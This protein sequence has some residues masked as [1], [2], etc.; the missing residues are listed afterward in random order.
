MAVGTLEI[1]QDIPECESIRVIQKLKQSSRITMGHNVIDSTHTDTK[2]AELELT[3]RRELAA[4]YRLLDYYHMTELT[5][6]HA[7]MRLPGPE[8]NFLLN[9]YGLLFEEI[10]ASNLVQV[11]LAG[12]IM[13]DRG[14]VISP[15]AFVIHSAIHEG[16]EDAKSILHLHTVDGSAVAA[17]RDGLLPVNQISMAFYNRLGYHDY[18]GIAYNKDER[19]LFIEDLA[20]NDAMVLRNHGLLTVGRSPGE[21]WIRMFYLHMACQIQVAAL[22][23]NRPLV[24]PDDDMAEHVARQWVG[25]AS[26][27]DFKEDDSLVRAWAAMLRMV[28]RKF[29]DYRD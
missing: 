18:H 28:D 24:L 3:L 8:R 25:T 26:A 23:G 4:V 9:L 11:D 27:D 16:R 7:S 12:K 2:D 13:Q 29:P 15:S 1:G 6:T 10:T 5:F 14:F 22:S 17:Q 20:D 19:K 21:A